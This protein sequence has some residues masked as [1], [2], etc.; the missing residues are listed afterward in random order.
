MPSAAR[1]KLFSSAAATTYRNCLSSISTFAPR[2]P[3]CG[4]LSLER[5]CGRRQRTALDDL[6]GVDDSLPSPPQVR[7]Y[8]S[9]A[10]LINGPSYVAAT[11]RPDDTAV[12]RQIVISG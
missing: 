8:A 9:E 4:E 3:E 10:A 2:D 7:R 11:L 1:R 5:P 12:S 6:A